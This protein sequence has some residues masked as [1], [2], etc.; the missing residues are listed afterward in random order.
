MSEEKRV[1]KKELED[2]LLNYNRCTPVTIVADV[3][4]DMNK[5]KKFILNES[6][7]YVYGEDGEPQAV[8]EENPYHKKVRCE[9]H[10]NG[11]INFDYEA[12]VKRQL[13]REGKEPETFEAKE[14]KWGVHVTR[15]VIEHKDN[16]Y[17]Q[18]RVGRSYN[19]NYHDEDNNEI[20]Y[21]TIKPFIRPKK[22]SD[23][24]GTDKEIV[25][26]DVKFDDSV[27]AITLDH[28]KYVIES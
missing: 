21:N 17:V 24:Q 14:R 5:K 6:N 8:T 15:A 12:A 20:D 1:S 10:I 9:K 16:Y 18:I 22:R 25:I 23:S 11:I 28:V 26:R 13:K 2:I 27:K 4:V 7:D 19:L 3:V